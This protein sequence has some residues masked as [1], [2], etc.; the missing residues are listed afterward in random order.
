M[1]RPGLPILIA[2]L[3]GLAGCGD[4]SSPE[5]STADAAA[6]AG[7]ELSV[8]VPRDLEVEA[9]WQVLF[10]DWSARTGARPG[11]V[12]P[13][14]PWHSLTADV[15]V[16]PVTSV[17]ELDALWELQPVPETLDLQSVLGGL[18]QQLCQVGREARLV[19]IS[20][21]VLVLYVRGDL[22]EASGKRLPETWAEYQQLLEELDEWAG[23]LTAVEPWGEEF[24][25]TM[26]LARAVSHARH[27]ANYSLFFEINRGDPLVDSPAFVRALQEAKKALTEMPAAVRNYTPADCRRELLAGRA[28]MA[29][30]FEPEFPEPAD[31]E[32]AE[33]VRV[34]FIRLPG[35]REIYNRS[36]ARWETV[37][38]RA[39]AT[40]L[41]GFAGLV[42]VVRKERQAA[43]AWDLV[44]E[45]LVE[46]R[47]EAIDGSVRGLCWQ[48]DVETVAEWLE[49]SLAAD[50]RTGYAR[51]V[52]AGLDEAGVV[53]ELGVLGRER[54]LAALSQS[55]D[56]WLAGETN[57]E[58]T[59]GNA[60]EQWRKILGE[61]GTE[62]VRDS[63]RRSLGLSAIGEDTTRR[64]PRR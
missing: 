31:V 30:S 26:F 11:L 32:R 62:T 3:I 45:V 52:V 14:W 9:T 8:A 38:G 50:E 25:A 33:T 37:V 49:G 18:R 4:E 48:E 46:R 43:A 27:P 2:G 10:E 21:P 40:S 5:T 57:A 7:T 53:L 61:I 12:T 42:A 60:A 64:P 6:W 63:Y 17:P 34:K 35:V 51:A 44:A 56:R 41:V 58:E 54:F 28:A 16:I 36:S 29:V 1:N 39:Q 47:R 24:R 59:L 23:G 20:T 55:L 13:A 19:P 22:L 15:A